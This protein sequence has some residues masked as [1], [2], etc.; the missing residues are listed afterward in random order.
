[1]DVKR[2]EILLVDDD[3][4]HIEL[5]RRSFESRNEDTILSFARSLGEARENLKNSTPDLVIADLRL[6]DGDGTELLSGNGSEGALPVVIL[7]GHGD[8]QA[9]VDAMK[10]GALD[11]VVKTTATLADMPRAAKRALREWNHIVERRRTEAE[12]R[13]SEHRFRDL[14]DGSPDAIFVEDSNGFVLDVNPAACELHKMSRGEL[15]GKNVVE[16]IP[17]EFRDEVSREFPKLVQ[18]EVDRFDGWSWTKDGRAVPIAL[19]CR[20]IDYEGQPALLLHVRDITERKRAEESLRESEERYR[21]F[22][23]HSNE[24]V[25]LCR[26]DEP[27]PI[28]LPEE[29]QIRRIHRGYCFETCNDAF[30]QMYGLS[31][32][33]DLIGKSPRDVDGREDNLTEQNRVTIRQWIRS[34]FRSL[35]ALTEEFDQDGNRMFVHNNQVGMVSDGHLTHVWATQR[36]VTHRIE[37]EEALH[38]RNRALASTSNGVL[39]TDPNQPDNPVIFCNAAFQTMTGYTEQETLG[40]NCRFL[41]GDDCD[42]AGLDEL[43][44]AIREQ[45]SCQVTLR[46]YRKN[47]E[48]FWN[49]LTLSPVFDDLKQLTHFVGIQN[50]ITDRKRAER[51]A[52]QYARQQESVARLGQCAVTNVDLDSLMD[53]IAHTVADTFDVEYCK[54]LECLPGGE[55][56]LLR[57]GVGWNE[58]LVG[59]ATVGTALQ[60]QAGYTLRADGPVIVE[61][62]RTET[63]FSGPPLLHN[64]GVV[65]GMSVI[66]HGAE[67]PFGVLGAHT[68]KRRTFSQEDIRFLQVVANL[69]ADAIQRKQAEDA[70][71]DREHRLR[72]ITNSVP[73]MIAYV[74]HERRYQFANTPYRETFGAVSEEIV[75]MHIS[76]VLGEVGYARARPHIDAALRGEAVTFEVEMPIK[77][78]PPLTLR[79]TLVPH[80]NEHGDVVGYYALVL[81]VTE[82]RKSE[83]ELR[84]SEQRYRSLLDNHVDAVGLTV[85]GK[86]VY[87]ND[88]MAN[89]T[90]YTLE[91]TMGCSP[92]EFIA[93]K[94]RQRAEKR[95]AEVVAGSSPTSSEYEFIHKD[96]HL[97]TVEIL[98]HVIQYAGKP[99]LLSVLRDVTQRKELEEMLRRADRLAS[100]GTLAAGIAHEI[101][102]PM[103]AAWTSAEMALKLRDKPETADLFEDS[104]HTVINSV[105]R[106]DQII[107]SVLRL[108]RCESS[109]KTPGDINDIARRAAEISQSYAK[110]QDATIELQLGEN[111]PSAVMNPIEIE[112]V[113]VNLIQNAIQASRGPAR[114]TILTEKTPQAIRITVKDRGRGIADS[115]KDQIFDPFFTDRPTGAGVGLGLSIVNSIVEEHGGSIDIRSQQN[116]G[117]TVTVVL[118]TEGAIPVAIGD[119]LT[120]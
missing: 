81:D 92:V 114:V 103:S 18:G 39:I 61:D 10:A 9:A 4:D 16:L 50:D 38:I 87:A 51:Q 95:I 113:V 37:A 34:G 40:R 43:R 23:E 45:R 82:Q 117:T 102:N 90:G 76:D 106:C 84:A 89:L 28:D 46:N 27:I 63:R 11:Y 72:L 99:A 7:T 110:E 66:I 60:S 31:R 20:K 54:V 65:S 93:P 88:Q 78:N 68:T 115:I 13:K 104:M 105:Q 108:V 85:D 52:A 111:L 3:Q 91:E 116:E 73:A 74:D 94:D 32:A 75:G 64:H 118:P 12:L 47:G 96:N 2:T 109:A 112:Q 22:I 42:Q 71:R 67:S 48:M 21:L 79:P 36:N 15:V 58:G 44:A 57:A 35:D 1:M 120:Q 119:T 100:T 56:V 24:G 29:E 70:L 62:L 101:N 55:Q 80:I 30:A 77:D 69:L 25:V 97:L 41:Q 33:G 107:K 98:S 53:E 17:P 49:E 6:P 14:F 5:V 86:I 19:R 59:N 8:E 83:D 26:F